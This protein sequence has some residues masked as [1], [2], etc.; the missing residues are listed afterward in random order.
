MYL[1]TNVIYV[2]V[3]IISLFRC[4]NYRPR[5]TII[6]RIM[7]N[8]ANRGNLQY[9]FAGNIGY[10]GYKILYKFVYIFLNSLRI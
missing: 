4:F 8:Y 9:I 10:T 2:I 7:S 5:L 6:R 3:I 1:L